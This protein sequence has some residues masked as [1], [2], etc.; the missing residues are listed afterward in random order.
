MVLCDFSIPKYENAVLRYGGDKMK[1][2]DVAVGYSKQSI[3]KALWTV[4][5]LLEQVC[6]I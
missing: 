4:E 6:G 3:P 1:H 2:D 5:G